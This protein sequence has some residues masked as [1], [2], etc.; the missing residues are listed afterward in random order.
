MVSSFTVFLYILCSL[1]ARI[2]AND[3][4]ALPGSDH[5]Q[6]RSMNQQTE[7]LSHIT[8]QKIPFQ[9]SGGQ[10]QTSLEPTTRLE[11][12]REKTPKV[13]STL[14]RIKY[15][16]TPYLKLEDGRQLFKYSPVEVVPDT[17]QDRVGPMTAEEIDF[18]FWEMK[19]SPSPKS[20]YQ[21]MNEDSKVAAKVLGSHLPDFY[22]YLPDVI[23]MAAKLNEDLLRQIA[24]Y[25][26]LVDWNSKPGMRPGYIFQLSQFIDILHRVRI[27]EPKDQQT[28]SPANYLFESLSDQ[29]IELIL[30]TCLKSS[31]LT[32]IESL[33]SDDRI[34][35]RI[36][37]SIFNRVIQEI[38]I[39]KESAKALALPQF[40]ARID[41]K[42]WGLLMAKLL[43]SD[44]TDHVL[45][46]IN[47]PI[48]IEKM[49]E[50]DFKPVAHFWLN[51]LFHGQKSLNYLVL[52]QVAS[53][54][55]GL[56]WGTS[57]YLWLSK[58]Y[59]TV[60]GVM[61]NKPEIVD[62]IPEKQVSALLQGISELTAPSI[63]FIT[64]FVKSPLAA[65]MSG[66]QWGHLL[67]SLIRYDSKA[68][69]PILH[70][71]AILKLIPEDAFQ[72]IAKDLALYPFKM[73]YLVDDMTLP[74]FS[75]W[76]PGPVW[77]KMTEEYLQK[78][79]DLAMIVLQ[80]DDITKRIPEPQLLRI[81]QQ[82]VENDGFKSHWPIDVM[83]QAVKSVTRHNSIRKTQGGVI[84]R[85][86]PPR[87]TSIRAPRI[88][89][90][91]A[92]RNARTMPFHRLPV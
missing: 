42:D 86:G 13:D 51:Q 39:T 54:I 21:G 60:V 8:Y 11:Y 61:L 53:R 83:A 55:S 7:F 14:Y 2:L 1:S 19:E 82:V 5:D 89:I 79:Q 56:E 74:A 49:S 66:D 77:G 22:K 64:S 47:Q 10:I 80:H 30:S 59:D 90:P 25:P 70:D 46:F 34:L 92:L 27:A 24:D 17:H 88:H 36:S 35:S 28:R 23:V 43:Q 31:K 72:A 50:S 20:I 84:A 29:R 67:H 37:Q 87:I 40:V 68:A 75:K 52:P 69:G 62:R 85:L 41:G 58:G 6:S 44:Q 81:Y 33:F 26:K 65:K 3:P 12:P 76:I 4:V 63:Y 48:I 38:P 16:K 9:L 91:N 57:L 78:N 71:S 15:R 18:V 45:F 32:T 73:T